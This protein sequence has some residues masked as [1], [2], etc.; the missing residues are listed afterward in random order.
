VRA[1]ANKPDSSP[2]STSTRPVPV[3]GSA[4]LAR[5]TRSALLLRLAIGNRPPQRLLQTKLSVGTPGDEYEREAESVA[6]QVMRMPDPEQG[7]G[8][9]SPLVDESVSRA[10]VQR[11]SADRDPSLEDAVVVEGGEAGEAP[12]EEVQTLRPPGQT[13]GREPVSAA[14][15]ES[16]QGGAPIDRGAR[17]YME[18]RFGADFSGVQVHADARAA[19]LSR[20]LSARA[21]AYGQHIYFNAGEYRPD[22]PEGKRVLA[23]ELTHVV[24]QRGGGPRPAA[25]QRMSARG[26]A[27]RHNVAPWGSGPTGTDYEVTT[28]AGSVLTGWGAYSPWQYRLSYWCHGHTLGTFYDHGYSVYSG[29]P[30]RT[31]IRDEWDSV[32]PDQTREGDIAVWTAGF[33]HSARFTQPV[34][35]NGLL[36]P[37]RSILSTKNGQAAVAN[38]TL[39]QIMAVYGVAGVAVFRH[40]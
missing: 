29:T 36:Q 40:K 25:I 4:R 30:M 1:Y 37:S 5:D 9:G 8:A 15:L 11:L 39:D 19:E 12:Q 6:D 17:D 38:R 26:T 31:V 3:A 34:V 28:D 2:R 35:E 13:S 16:A 24:Q 7:D 23:H 18:P 32:P 27:I 33:D 10:S 21:F 22:T 14:A 20:S